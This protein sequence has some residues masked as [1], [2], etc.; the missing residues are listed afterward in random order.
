VNVPF[1]GD[2]RKHF[3]AL[4]LQATVGMMH[5]LISLIS[6]IAIVNNSEPLRPEEIFR[7]YISNKRQKQGNWLQKPGYDVHA[8]VRD[9]GIIISATKIDYHLAYTLLGGRFAVSNDGLTKRQLRI[10]E[11]VKKWNMGYLKESTFA[12]LENEYEG[13]ALIVN[14]T[15]CW[16]SREKIVE[17]VN[18]EDD[19]KLS[20]STIYYE[21]KT[22]ERKGVIE[23]KKLPGVKNKFGYYVL[24]LEAGNTV[25]LPKP[26]TIIDPI[27]KGEKV[28]V[29]NPVTGEVEEI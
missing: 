17:L 6:L 13:L 16:V 8:K 12:Q 25:I 7:T 22:L 26:S 23:Y 10:Y 9:Q 4:K 11:A 28:K 20:P 24:T 21:L 1:F 14:C 5:P 29:M 18:K 19:T 2:L 3:D 15:G 27:L